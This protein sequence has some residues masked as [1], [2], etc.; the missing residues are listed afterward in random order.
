MLWEFQLKFNLN[1]TIILTDFDRAE[2]YDKN[3]IHTKLR[4]LQSRNILVI[5]L[6]AHINHNYTQ[7]G[8]NRTLESKFIIF[9]NIHL[10]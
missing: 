6:G 7:K 1:N 2:L 10:E 5:G 4:N 9:D 3:N 8:G